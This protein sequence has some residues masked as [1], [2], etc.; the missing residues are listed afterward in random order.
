V[1]G[2]SIRLVVFDMAGTIIDHGSVAP[3]V[4]LVAAFRELGLEL[5]AEHARGPMGLQKRDHIAQVLQVPEIVTRW[6]QVFGATPTSADGDA[7]YKRFLPLQAAEAQ[8]RTE[9]IPG[10]LSALA[11]L[12]EKKVAVGTTTGY[13]RMIGEPIVEALR[14][15]GWRADHA[16]F[17]DDVPA[18]RP[19]PWMMFR[20]MELTGV[21]PASAVVK[22]GDTVPDIEEG[23]NAG[24]WTI[25]VT[26]TGS[27]MG[28][29]LA[30]WEALPKAE[31]DRR[32]SA[33]GKKLLRA[34]A[35]TVIPSVGCLPA[36]L[37]EVNEKLQGGKQ[38]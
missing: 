34:G 7:I 2:P 19:A 3:V 16:I 1:T 17:P 23:R 12:R 15:Q 13:P 28:L 32:A 36:L 31:R 29:T 9:L 5:S 37:A 25:G 14:T 21:Y 11:E 10:A 26:Q 35:H 27:E 20:L 38:P 22:I 33:A 4:A 8:A 6:K 30:E 18:G 24:A